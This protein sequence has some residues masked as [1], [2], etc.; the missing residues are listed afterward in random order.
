MSR[1]KPIFRQLQS[2]IKDGK[3]YALS[4]DEYTGKNGKFKFKKLSENY[5]DN[6]DN[7]IIFIYYLDKK[8]LADNSKP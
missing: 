4:F 5:L 8:F 6:L 3:R 2:G 7:F 1:P